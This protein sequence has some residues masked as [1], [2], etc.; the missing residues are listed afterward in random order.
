[1]SA[2]GHKQ[3]FALQKAMSALP[4]IATAKA[5]FRTRSCLLYR[6]KRTCAVHLLM[7][8]LGQKR[9][10]PDLFNHLVCAG[11]QRWRHCDAERFGG[12]QV[13]HYFEFGRLF[14][15]QFGRLCP[16]QNLVDVVSGTPR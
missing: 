1:M 4:P 15:R 14:D 6:R 5:D 16:A 10:Y 9:T 3:T 11:E 8:A 13:D 12:N 2:L 7:S